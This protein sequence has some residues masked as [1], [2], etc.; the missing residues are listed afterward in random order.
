MANSVV[1]LQFKQLFLPLWVSTFHHIRQQLGLLLEIAYLFLHHLHFKALALLQNPHSFPQ[2]LILSPQSL[3][4][5]LQF[6]LPLHHPP[7]LLV[8]PQPM[9]GTLLL[10]FV[11]TG[12]LNN[13]QSIRPNNFPRTLTVHI[14]DLV[15]PTGISAGSWHSFEVGIGRRCMEEIWIGVVVDIG[16]WIIAGVVGEY[17]LLF[18]LSEV[19]VT[20]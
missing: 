6:K 11:E 17:G 16:R 14:R 5:S 4:L 12:L 3:I 2:I 1:I 7:G 9:N 8:G 18:V 10:R 15:T 13:L 20:V 19:G